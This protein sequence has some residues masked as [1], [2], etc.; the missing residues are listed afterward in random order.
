MKLGL[1]QIIYRVPNIGVCLP[2]PP[3][4]VYDSLDVVF[5]PAVGTPVIRTYLSWDVSNVV[6]V[7]LRVFRLKRSICTVGAFAVRFEAGFS[8]AKQ[9][10]EL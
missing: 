9:S 4:S 3:R 7:P 6:L 2:L 5:F 10:L 8:L 1:V